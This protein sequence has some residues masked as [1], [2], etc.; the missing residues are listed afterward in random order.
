[1]Y[2]EVKNASGVV[3]RPNAVEY[4]DF[5]H[6]DPTLVQPYV[7]HPG[8]SLT[9][10]CYFHNP[11]TH[12]MYFGPGS[13]E[14]MCIDFIYYYPIHESI[15]VNGGHCT[16]PSESINNYADFGG[17]FDGRVIT[18]QDDDGMRVFGTSVGLADDPSCTGGGIT[19][20]DAAAAENMPQGTGK[21]EDAGT[22]A[23]AA[24]G[25]LLLMVMAT[26][27]TGVGGVL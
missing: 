19:T 20:K 2:T 14:E 18:S 23:A 21:T 13:E 3:T 5:D 11:T 7:I 22:R 12:D 17:R 10:R 16:M 24:A 8:D 9:T 1:M 25:V 4:F 15:G 27:A 6:Q 26:T